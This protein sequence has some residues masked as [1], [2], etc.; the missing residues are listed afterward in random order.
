MGELNNKQLQRDL[1]M[2]RDRALDDLVKVV[3]GYALNID[4]EKWAERQLDKLVGKA[5]KKLKP[6]DFLRR[7]WDS[8]GF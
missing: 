5:L 4:I 3:A 7:F 1:R 2:W 6:P 8:L